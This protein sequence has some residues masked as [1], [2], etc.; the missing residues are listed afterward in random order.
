MEFKKD[1][2]YQTTHEWSRKDGNEIVVGISDYAQDA[3]N[4]IVYVELP[5]PG[6]SFDKG[7]TFGVVESVKSASDVYMP[8]SG[9]IVAINEALD[10]KPETVNEDP[11]GAGWLIRVKPS[12]PDEWNSLLSVEEYEASTQEEA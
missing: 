3:L 1:V 10:E 11:F 2:R 4:D 7:D 12:N 5:E 8:V 6:D 9:E